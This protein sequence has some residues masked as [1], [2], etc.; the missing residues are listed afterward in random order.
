[1]SED[2]LQSCERSEESLTS[3]GETTWTQRNM[4]SVLMCSHLNHI[5]HQ[6]LLLTNEH[7]HAGGDSVSPSAAFHSGHHLPP[8]QEQFDHM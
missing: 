3:V 7:Q 2:S 8:T 4:S 1:M 5:S 6:P